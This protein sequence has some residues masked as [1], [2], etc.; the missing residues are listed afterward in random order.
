L[1]VFELVLSWKQGSLLGSVYVFGY[2]IALARLE[3]PI[4]SLNRLATPAQ[5]GVVRSLPRFE[6]L[7]R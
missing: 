5:A 4:G 3:R 2:A 1:F 6:N 7:L